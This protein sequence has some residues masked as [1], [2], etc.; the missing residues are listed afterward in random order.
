MIPIRETDKHGLVSY[1]GFIEAIN[2]GENTVILQGGILPMRITDPKPAPRRLLFTILPNAH[3]IRS[4]DRMRL[5]DL[6]VGEHAHLL[7]QTAPDGRLLTVSVSSGKPRGYPIAPT[8]L[9]LVRS[10][11]LESLPA[12]KCAAPIRRRFSLR[13]FEPRAGV[14]GTAC[15]VHRGVL[16]AA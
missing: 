8:P 16:A 12:R 5:R 7:A 2:P 11:L 1:E 9:R 10:T 4:S 15:D 6:K 13:R 14:P 3:V